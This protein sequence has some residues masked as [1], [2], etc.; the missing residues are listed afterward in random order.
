[1]RSPLIGATLRQRRRALGIAQAALA[2]QLGISASYLNLIESDKRNIAGALLK[3]VAD[4]LGFTLDEIDGAAERR[5]VADLGELCGEPLLADLGLE[6]A[7][8]QALAG[9]QRDWG[10]ALVRLHRA[11]LDRGQAVSALSDRLHQ[12]PF[13][14][15]AVHSLLTQVTAIRSSA[16]ILQTGEGLDPARRERFVAIVDEQSARLA[17]VA[18]SLAA[19]FDKDAAGTRSVTPAD[20]VDDFIVDLDNHFPPLE[21]AAAAFRA[22]AAIDGDCSEAGL[23]DYLRREHGVEVVLRPVQELDPAGVRHLV[24][25]DASASTLV[26][27]EE[28]VPATRRFEL[29]RLACE[30][31]GQGRAVQDLLAEAPQLTTDEARERARR[32]LSSYLAAAVLL[33]YDAFLAA[34]RELRYDVDR[35][36]QR[37]GASFEQVCHRLVTLRRPGASGIPFAL[38]RVDAAGFTSKR[39]PL[40]RLALPRHGPAC[41]MWAVYQALHV[42]GTVVRQLVEFPDGQ[43]LLFIARTVEKSR[44]AFL[45]PRRLQ[46]IMLAC[47]ALHADQTVYATGLDLSSS[48]PAVPVGPSCRLCV[49]RDCVYRAEE[50][51]VGR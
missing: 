6:E 3:R 9:R 22:D 11:W 36:V 49:R 51:I 38:M 27:A 23:V 46:S 45:L 8:A 18:R 29:V 24:S 47:D 14:G 19:F 37:F 50:P 10:R 31:H 20:E 43:R 41:P 7:G 33:P 21:Q 40:P 44:P 39:F 25:F 17:E 28:A 15:D 32:A 35:L 2:A 1:M 4:A 34:A 42:P 16:E 48:G 30:L 13:L 5:L 26:I 12:D